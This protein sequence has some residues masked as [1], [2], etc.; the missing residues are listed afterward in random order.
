MTTKA[1]KINDAL[2]AASAALL[3]ARHLLAEAGVPASAP[4]REQITQMRVAL[5]CMDAYY[6][7][8]PKTPQ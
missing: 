7:L 8:T 2:D 1:Q 5:D 4:E 3:K 6:L